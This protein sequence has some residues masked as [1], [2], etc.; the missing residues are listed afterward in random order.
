MN[1]P[2]NPS[3]S[4]PDQNAAPPAADP[5]TVAE[6]LRRVARVAAAFCV[7]LG[8]SLL[9]LYFRAKQA[10]PFQSPEMPALK[11][12]LDQSPKDEAL[13]QRI[14]E[15]DLELRERYFGHL[16]RSRAGGWLLLVGLV[17]W[18][19]SAR[20]A[21][22]LTEP[23]PHPR[24][25]DDAAERHQ[26]LSARARRA[27]AVTGAL[28][29]GG[30]GLLAVTTR[31][32]LPRTTAELA[33]LE[34]V[35]K[36]Q[37]AEAAPAPRLPSRE[38]YLANW[39]RFLGPT[40]NLAPVHTNIPVRWNAETGENV[41]WKAPVPLPG[42]NSPIVWGDRV[43]LCGGDVNQ[44]GVFCYDANTG[45][46]LWRRDVPRSPG[47]TTKQLKELEQTGFSAPT[48]ATDG[49]RVYAVFATGDLV[50]CDLD[51]N[52]LWSQ[53]RGVPDDPYGHAVSLY[54]DRDRLVLQWDQG[55]EG[56]A[57]SK[58]LLLDG[59]TGK[60]VWETTR[61]LGAN[62]A[63][64]II[65][66]AADKRQIITL[67]GMYVVSYNLADGKEL[68]RLECLGG[69]LTPSP[70]YA[71]GL[72]LATS[73]SDRL[74]A[75]RPDGSGELGE[76]ALVWQEDEEVPDIVTPVASTNRVFT[77]ATYGYLICFNLADGKKVW[78][79]DL[80]VECNATPALVGNRLY[81]F[82]TDGTVVVGR[83]DG[84]AFAELARFEM[85]EGFHASPAFAPGRMFLRGEKTL[86]AIGAKAATDVAAK[87]KETA[88]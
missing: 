12:R 38:E 58:L 87:A 62:W 56:D 34:A 63:T 49:L 41:L 88:P 80:E 43:F 65:I 50:A 47:V 53:A 45:A 36:E 60:P 11:A 75:M 27:V 42:F 39:P 40:G 46:L 37:A 72:V 77:L 76:D 57:V 24:F 61:D 59:A 48:M 30:L 84:D 13:K 86:F 69:E 71:G 52:P 67:G 66:E 9:V 10:D 7:V 29:L 33:A 28:S 21:R 64:G 73:P 17:T 68:W 31:T 5:L 25:S 35:E 26:R 6:A 81:L 83:V 79:Q 19:A 18:V 82:G 14:R 85:G 70:I 22:K 15:L 20:R 44:R 16:R 78:E 1:S 32:V 3:F 23:P 55:V 51:G 8:L 54:T 4:A 74:C 2:S